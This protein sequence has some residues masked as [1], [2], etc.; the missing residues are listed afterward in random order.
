MVKDYGANYQHGYSRLWQPTLGLNWDLPGGWR[1][2]V[3]VN[4]GEDKENGSATPS[5][6]QYAM[7][8][9]PIRIRQPRSIHSGTAATPIRPRSRA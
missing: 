6:W 1:A 4:Y 2:T 9:L 7:P 8:R 3:S 5:T